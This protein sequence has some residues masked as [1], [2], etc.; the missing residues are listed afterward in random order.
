MPNYTS[1]QLYGMR[2]QYEGELSYHARVWEGGCSAFLIP[3]NGDVYLIDDGRI[4]K[5]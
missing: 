5:G 1:G 3:E 4:V 2:S